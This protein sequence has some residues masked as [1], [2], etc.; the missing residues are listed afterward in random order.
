MTQA[1]VIL[2]SFSDEGSS[3]TQ[4]YSCFFGLIRIVFLFLIYWKCCDKSLISL[5]TI[6]KLMTLIVYLPKTKNLA[7]SRGFLSGS[8]V[9]LWGDSYGLERVVTIFLFT[10][11]ANS[12]ML[13]IDSRPSSLADMVI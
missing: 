13:R 1:G 3:L 9:L 7:D 4:Q 6:L 8:G 10:I 2:R 11:F 5:L 12:V